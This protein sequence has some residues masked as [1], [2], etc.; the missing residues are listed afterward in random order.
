MRLLERFSAARREPR[1]DQLIGFLGA[2]G[3]AEEAACKAL[4]WDA[5]DRCD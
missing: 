4:L 5:R 2:V 3:R 1:S